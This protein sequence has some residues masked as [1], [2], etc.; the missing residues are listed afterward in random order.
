MKKY[1]AIFLGLAGTGLIG[2]SVTR[3]WA[4]WT[5]STQFG[6]GISILNPGFDYWQGI[7]AAILAA[8]AFIL[9]FVKPK[10]AIAP[11]LLA[12]GVSLWAYLIPP[13]FE[14]TQYEPTKAIFIAVAGGVI[15]A[16]AGLIAPKKA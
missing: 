10:V 8:L 4:G 14:G 9:L 13:T 5:Q 3:G 1:L 11:A 6:Q 15:L 12:A 7:A 2:Y 16:L